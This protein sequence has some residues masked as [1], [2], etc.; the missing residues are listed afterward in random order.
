MKIKIK[1]SKISS[2]F[3]TK[4]IKRKIRKLFKNIHGRKKDKNTK[5]TKQKKFVLL[6]V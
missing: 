2:K 6:A 1:N 3:Y 5:Y 4:N